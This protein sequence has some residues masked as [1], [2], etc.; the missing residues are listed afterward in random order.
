MSK[1]FKGL[2]QGLQDIIDYQDGKLDLR[3]EFIEIPEP[4]NEYKA[5]DIKKIREQHK[6]SQG[7]FAR[8]LNVSTKTVQSWEPGRRSTTSSSLRLIEM[9][10]KG[11]STH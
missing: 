11:I 9:I 5:K 3:T 2:K 1:F 4:P 6:Y 7:I 8:I 10:D